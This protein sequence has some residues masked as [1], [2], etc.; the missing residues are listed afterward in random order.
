MDVP[1]YQEI[2]D[3]YKGVEHVIDALPKSNLTE[4]AK[5][6]LDIARDLTY[7]AREGIKADRTENVKGPAFEA[8][9]P[10][11]SGWP[12]TRG[13]FGNVT[14]LIHPKRGETSC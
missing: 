12:F 13:S 14:A 7:R 2:E 9:G 1:Q 11:M 6:N 4:R 5:A 8:R 3:A 10:A